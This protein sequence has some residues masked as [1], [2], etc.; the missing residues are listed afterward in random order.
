[1]KLRLGL[2]AIVGLL[3]GCDATG[4]VVSRAAGLELRVERGSLEVPLLLTG[5]LEADSSLELSTPRTQPVELTIQWLAEDGAPVKK[6]DPLVEF[7]ATALMSS[8]GELEIGMLQAGTELV[9]LR[10]K[11]AVEVAEKRFAERQAQLEADKAKIDA[12]TPPEIL[13]RIKYNEF[14]LL[15]GRAQLGYDAAKVDEDVATRGSAL[16]EKVSELS[17]DKAK[18]KYVAARDELGSLTLRAPQDGVMI[19]PP[20]FWQDRKL[21]VGDVT[22]PGVTVAKLPDLSKMIVRAVLSDVDDGR[23]HAGMGVECILDAR[24][25]RSFRGLVRSVNPVA[26]ELSRDATRRFFSVVIELDETDEAIMRPG[27]SV[28][29]RVVSDRKEDVLLI[30]RVALSFEGSKALAYDANGASHPVEIGA[31]NAEHCELIGGLEPGQALG[32]A[33]MRLLSGEGEG[34]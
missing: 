2:L 29:V 11:Q 34:S 22:F 13:S 4:P 17:Y 18:R 25:N 7:D 27:L 24:P 28:Q 8:I 15:Y 1:V 10:S 31:C 3:P 30:P 32:R 16:E 9:N 5:E 6:G 26:R 19:V 20:H 33:P 14:Q 21:Q 12:D 23:V